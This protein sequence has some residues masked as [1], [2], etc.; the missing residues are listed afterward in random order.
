MSKTLS[1]KGMNNFS[2][3]VV[4]LTSNSLYGVFIYICLIITL[5][6]L[7]NS[8]KITL[9][10][11]QSMAIHYC[12]HQISVVNVECLLKVWILLC[13]CLVARQDNLLGSD[14]S[15]KSLLTSL[16]ISVY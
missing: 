7:K 8:L 11:T 4:F 2:V 6:N 12:Q 13:L 5:Y 15:Y 14:H 1:V 3:F 10:T 16:F 9:T